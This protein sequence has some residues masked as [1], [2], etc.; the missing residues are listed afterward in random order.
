M[1][2]IPPDARIRI[3]YRH[4][5]GPHQGEDI[6]LPLKLLVMGNFKGYRE[7]TPLAEREPAA[8]T[9]ETFNEVMAAANIEITLPGNGNPSQILRICSLEDFHPDCI[10]QQLPN[11][12]HYLQIR[13]TLVELKNRLLT[14]QQRTA[15]IKS[16][17]SSF[18]AL[19]GSQ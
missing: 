8:I 12:R 4:N 11:T 13:Q 6:E 9:L 17:Q 5:N 16:L 15:M 3:T 18:E 14:E 10:L 1:Q 2:E 19:I 7:D